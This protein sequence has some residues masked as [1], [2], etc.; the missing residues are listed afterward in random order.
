MDQWPLNMY[1]V[2]KP[3]VSF[4]N[5]MH[6]S[7]HEAEWPCGAGADPES[8]VT[9]PTTFT[10]PARIR[11]RARC[12]TRARVVSPDE[13]GMGVFVGHPHLTLVSADVGEKEI[14]GCKLVPQAPSDASVV[15]AAD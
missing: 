14:A 1:Q 9:P 7:Q 6:A 10:A 11:P 8:C 2:T 3:P 15:A 13:T 4:P 5:T 12:E